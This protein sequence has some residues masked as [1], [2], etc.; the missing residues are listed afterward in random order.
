MFFTLIK[1]INRLRKEI[2]ILLSKGI[3]ML[4]KEIKRLLSKWINRSRKEMNRLSSKG[5]SNIYLKPTIEKNWRSQ[6]FDFISLKISYQVTFWGDPTHPDITEFYNILLQLKNRK[7]IMW[8]IVPGIWSAIDRI[9]AI[10]D[11]F[12]SLLPH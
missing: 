9:F 10:L 4:R 7:T 11:H 6:T 3:N 2:N 1:E 5:M 8:C 12:F